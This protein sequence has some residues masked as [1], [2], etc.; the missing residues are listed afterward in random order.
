[1]GSKGSVGLGPL[2][3]GPTPRP[4][5]ATYM[6]FALRPPRAAAVTTTWG[7]SAVGLRPTSVQLRAGLVRRLGRRTSPARNWT[8]VGRIPTAEDPQVVVT[9]A[10]RGGRKA[11]LMYVAARGLGV[12]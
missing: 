5:A 10:A 11:K 6:S 8:L 12:G 7:S 2:T 9:A 4:R 1:M 3:F